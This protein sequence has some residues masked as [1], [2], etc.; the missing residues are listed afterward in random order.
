MPKHVAPFL[1][2]V[3][4]SVSCASLAQTTPAA[5]R[6]S[7]H[8]LGIGLKHAPVYDGADRNEWRAVPIVSYQGR[9]LMARTTQGFPEAGAFFEPLPGIRVGASLTLAGGR[10]VSDAELPAVKGIE[11]LDPAAAIG[12]FIEADLPVGPVPVRLT[13]RWRQ[14][15]D[16]DRGAQADVRL[17]V[18]LYRDDA[19]RLEAFG[20][21]TWADADAMASEYGISASQ[22]AASGLA[23]YRPG[24]GLRHAALGLRGQWNLGERWAVVGLLE[25]R[26]LA[27]AVQDSPLTASKD[28]FEA[29]AGLAYRFR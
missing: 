4:A 16:S 13:A 19:L 21:L 2:A 28:G 22:S 29:T 5:D 6:S 15:F 11:D 18:G 7:E 3:L 10:A 8:L 27:D 14:A 26:R 17:G 20:Q 25:Y 1:L 23:A 12:P 9:Y 24:A